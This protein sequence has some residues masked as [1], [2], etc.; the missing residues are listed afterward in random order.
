MEKQ[1]EVVFCTT[2]AFHGDNTRQSGVS[3][4]WLQKLE[5]VAVIGEEGDKALLNPWRE[6][7]R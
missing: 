5:T 2:F 4:S 7:E 6:R 3:I 1:A